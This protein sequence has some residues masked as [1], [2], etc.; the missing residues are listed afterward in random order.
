M[1]RM[2]QAADISYSKGI[3]L[4]GQL[5]YAFYVVGVLT[6][7]KKACSSQESSLRLGSDSFREPIAIMQSFIRIDCRR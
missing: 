5:R 4:L 1:G 7:R 6:E 3:G 2:I